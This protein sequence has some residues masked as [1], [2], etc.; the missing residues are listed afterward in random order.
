MKKMIMPLMM[1]LSM[2]IGANAQRLDNTYMEA[3]IL[4][5]YMA[6]EL[7]LNSWQREKA[8][9]MNLD[10]LNGIGSYHD[11]DAHI[12]TLRNNQLKSILNAAQ[13]KLYKKASYFYRPIS[14]KQGAY[15]HNIYAKYPVAP[16]VVPGR[17]NRVTKPM[18]QVNRPVTLPLM[19]NERPV[20][21]SIK[22]NPGNMMAKKE[23][24][25]RSFGSMRR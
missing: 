18:P 15:V 19:N 11:I 8:Y 5:D 7:S 22:R 13:W 23:E 1:V 24:P 25:K 17:D 10:Y 21:V 12:W 14:W 9:Q 2:T 6:D 4:T 3:R 20:N 16:R